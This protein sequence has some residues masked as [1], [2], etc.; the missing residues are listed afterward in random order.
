MVERS[1]RR[2][3]IV[4]EEEYCD[5]LVVREAFNCWARELASIGLGGMG[6]VV[7]ICVIDFEKNFSSFW[8]L[9]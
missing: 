5:E 6:R 9:H 1:R 8:T 4:C 7:T 3:L 2:G